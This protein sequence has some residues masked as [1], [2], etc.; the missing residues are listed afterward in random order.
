ML[1]MLTNILDRFTSTRT[2]TLTFFPQPAGLQRYPI[3]EEKQTIPVTARL[4][5]AFLPVVFDD[6]EELE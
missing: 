4:R 5:Q 3:S 6:S 2:I 1:M